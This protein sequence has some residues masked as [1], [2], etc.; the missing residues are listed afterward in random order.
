MFK[1]DDYSSTVIVASGDFLSLEV[2][3]KQPR[4]AHSRALIDLLLR[5]D[6]LRVA[7][8]VFIDAGATMLIVPTDVSNSIAQADEI[9]NGAISAERLFDGARDAVSCVRKAVEARGAK[10]AVVG[11]IGPVDALVTLN[12]ID[13]A[14][15]RDA[16]ARQARALA[17]GA[18]DA[19]LC[20]AFTE[21][22]AAV[23]AVQAAR[24]STNLP[25][26]ASMIYDS[27]AE[28]SQTALGVTIPQACRALVEAG[29][30]LIGCD[31]SEYPDGAPAVVT[32][33]RQSCELPVYVEITAG[34]A[35]LSD[36][37]IVYPES[38][39]SFG[40]RLEAIIAAGARVIAGGSGATAG[41]IAELAKMGAR[42]SRRKSRRS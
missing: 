25:V 34:R 12:E 22:E 39:K 35:E 14:V 15:L 33:I 5:H 37:G 16:F 6:Q 41:H 7:A 8:E 26:F 1:F 2:S 3:E 4:V 11:A 20:R 24:E 42:L 28:F 13:E 38:P 18:A 27:G 30:C 21:L 10:I 19:I 23:I 32:L 9:A 29:A 40:E 36:D 17:D 31:G